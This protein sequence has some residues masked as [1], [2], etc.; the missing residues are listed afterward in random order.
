MCVDSKRAS[1]GSHSLCMQIAHQQIVRCHRIM[2]SEYPQYEAMGIIGSG[3]IYPV[4]SGAGV[5]KLDMDEVPGTDKES[6]K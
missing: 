4:I 6:S 3:M 2:L 1:G 5:E